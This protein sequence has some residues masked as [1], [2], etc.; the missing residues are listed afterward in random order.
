MSAP[1]DLA[2]YCRLT[3]ITYDALCFEPAFLENADEG[4]DIQALAASLGLRAHLQTVEPDDS[5]YDTEDHMSGR[6]ALSAVAEYAQTHSALSLSD[7]H[8]VGLWPTQDGDFLALWV[9]PLAVS[10]G[11]A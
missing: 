2:T 3:R 7:A 1:L 11:A 9:E 6:P 10:A 4:T 5:C 8:L